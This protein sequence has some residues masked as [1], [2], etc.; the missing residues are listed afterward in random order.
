MCTTE[1]ARF[2]ESN[3][4]AVNF[5][6]DSTRRLVKAGCASDSASASVEDCHVRLRAEYASTVG[7]DGVNRRHLV[8]VQDLGMAV[9]PALVVDMKDTSAARR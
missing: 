2:V 6:V 1:H 9:R 8:G 4:P 5:N 3:G 7:V